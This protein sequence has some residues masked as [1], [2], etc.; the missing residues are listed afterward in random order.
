MKTRI[1]GGLCKMFTKDEKMDWF[2]SPRCV[3]AGRKV[4]HMWIVEMKECLLK[5]MKRDV[6]K[7]MPLL[8]W[9]EMRGAILGEI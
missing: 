4:G 6:C 5:D 3:N 9:M 1:S 7:N 2:F 8:F